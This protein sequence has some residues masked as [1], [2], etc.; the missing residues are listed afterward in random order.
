MEVVWRYND[1]ERKLVYIYIYILFGGR[2][3]ATEFFQAWNN[4]WEN[5]S[6]QQDIPDSHLMSQNISRRT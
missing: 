4:P 3:Q 2:I 1:H 5:S 6:Y